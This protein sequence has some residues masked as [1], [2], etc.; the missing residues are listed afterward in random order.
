MV[1][2][3]PVCESLKKLPVGGLSNSNM[4]TIEKKPLPVSVFKVLLL[5]GSWQ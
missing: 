5:P 3:E 1:L 2:K 4:N